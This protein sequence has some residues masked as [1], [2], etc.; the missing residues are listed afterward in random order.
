MIISGLNQKR[1]MKSAE[2]KVIV[3][4][5]LYLLLFTL[6]CGFKSTQ[7]IA[8]GMFL[9]SPLVVITMVFTVLKKGIYKGR[10]L[11]KNEFGY[12]DRND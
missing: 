8:V 3:A 7:S 5:S 11:N 2:I 12:S 10:E 6:L 4:A 9:L 1:V